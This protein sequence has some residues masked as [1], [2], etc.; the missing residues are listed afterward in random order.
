MLLSSETPAIS[1][2]EDRFVAIGRSGP[3][4]ILAVIHV[5]RHEAIRIVSAR[6]ATARER[7]L[8]DAR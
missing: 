7:G 6:R 5:P 1:E 8:Y 3:D 4:L 2:D